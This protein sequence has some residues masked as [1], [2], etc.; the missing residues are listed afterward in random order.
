[1]SACPNERRSQRGFNVIEL[2]VV[3]AIV[4]ATAGVVVPVVSMKKLDDQW[5][6]VDDD[7]QSIATAINDFVVETRT[8]PTGHTG[9]TN[10]HFLYSDGV[11]PR[12]NVFESGPATHVGKFLESGDLANDD[13]KGP[14][15]DHGIGPDP[16]GNAYLVNVNGFY[17]SSERVL[18]VCAGPNGQV[19]TAPSATVAG[20]DDIVL[21]VD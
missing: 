7:L 5:R 14:Y 4:L 19:N 18:I 12:N 8:F 2:L 11:R 6:R 20:G 1:M 3:V 16:W 17:N 10:Y 21:V 9:A 15:L 13:W